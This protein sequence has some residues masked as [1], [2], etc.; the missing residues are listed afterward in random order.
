MNE[1]YR[2]QDFAGEFE[3]KRDSKYAARD[4]KQQ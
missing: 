3:R 2:D 4:F 1:V